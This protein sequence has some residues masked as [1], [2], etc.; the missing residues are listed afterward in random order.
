MGGEKGGEIGK[1]ERGEVGTIEGIGIQVKDG[2]RGG[3]GGGGYD[4]FGKAGAYDDEVEGGWI[5]WGI[6]WDVVHGE[7]KVENS[8]Y[9]AKAPRSIPCSQS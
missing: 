8:H 4:G 2:F 9:N 3:R 5:N 7:A 1:R 6:G